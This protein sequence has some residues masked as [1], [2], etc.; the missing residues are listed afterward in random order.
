MITEDDRGWMREALELAGRGSALASPNP[1]VGAVVLDAAGDKAGEGFHRYAAVAHA[2]ALALEQAGER[3]KGGTLYVT[4]EPCSHQ[5]RTAPCV[6]AVIA[7]GIKR[8]VCP[9]EDES[10]K[11]SGAGFRRLHEAGIEVDIMDEL[12]G[13]ARRLNEDFF[14]YAKTGLPLVTLKTAA[15]LDGKISPRTITRAGSRPR[16]RAATCKPCG[17]VTTPS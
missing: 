4:L 11:V 8:V 9:L 1:V 17:T 2:E 14:H 15:T 12:S 16:S 13:L 6:D 3:A 7:A 10:P 5:G